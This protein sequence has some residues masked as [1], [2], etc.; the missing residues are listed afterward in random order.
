MRERDCVHAG[1]EQ[2][3]E[4]GRQCTSEETLRCADV[5]EGKVRG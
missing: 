1:A 2:E 5:M 4:G 3:K